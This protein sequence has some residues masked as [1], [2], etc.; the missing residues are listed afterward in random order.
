MLFYLCFDVYTFESLYIFFKL[1]FSVICKSLMIFSL[2]FYFI[3]ELKFCS[4]FRCFFWENKEKTFLGFWIQK[5]IANV[6]LAQHQSYIKYNNNRTPNKLMFF[7]FLL[8][9][10]C[11]SFSFLFSYE[12]PNALL[13]VNLICVFYLLL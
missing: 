2:F 5:N 10:F 12:K 11:S 7:L 6:W 1:L 3:Y 4:L 13:N 8:F 9:A